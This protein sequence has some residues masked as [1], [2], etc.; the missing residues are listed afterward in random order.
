MFRRILIFTLWITL[1]IGLFFWWLSQWPA[2]VSVPEMNTD[3]LWRTIQKQDNGWRRSE[4]VPDKKDAFVSF[5]EKGLLLYGQGKLPTI[6]KSD[7]TISIYFEAW[8]WIIRS[9]NQTQKVAVNFGATNFWLE[10]AGG[11]FI[12]IENNIVANF[13][14]EMTLNQ[15]ELLPAFL[16]RNGQQE[17]FDIWEQKEL[18]PLDLWLVYAAFFPRDQYAAFF[19]KDKIKDVWDTDISKKFLDNMLKVLIA[20]EPLTPKEGFIEYD[21]RAKNALLE[22]QLIIAKI[23]A[24]ESCGADSASCFTLLSEIIEREKTAFPA[25]FSPLEHAVQAWMQLNIG[26]QDTGYSWI[27]IFRTYHIQLLNGDPRARATRDKSI[28]E[29]IKTWN[30]V[31]SLE[32][33]DYLTQMLASQKLGSAYS[34]QI[35][36]EMIRIGDL[37]QKS[38]DIPEP[39]KKALAKNAI[40]SLSNLKNILENTYFTKKEYW[41]VLRTDLVDDEGNTIKNYIFVNDLQELIKQIDSSAFI[42][43]S[44]ISS[45]KNLPLIRAQLAWFNCIFSRNDE[46]VNN[47]RICRTTRAELGE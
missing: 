6:N 44:D 15:K 10:G 31:S 33:W 27:S 46:Y 1:W 45:Q 25:V 12:D 3:A 18:I 17:F 16:S 39:T 4:Y 37:L 5:Q 30:T 22:I 13:D 32:I 14:A 7:K 40:E 20:R 34:L 24:G 23:D 11:A 26:K 43:W 19:P 36:R 42:Q 21:M 9:L 35:V 47:P 8:K 2:Q 28:L 38:Q 29:M 41:F